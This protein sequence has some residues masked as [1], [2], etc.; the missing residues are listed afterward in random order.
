MDLHARLL[1]LEREL[2]T[3]RRRDRRWWCAAIAAI[4]VALACK[5]GDAKVDDYVRRGEPIVIG[6]VT[7]GTDF[8]TVSDGSGNAQLRSRGLAIT[9]AGASG[10]TTQVLAGRVFGDGTGGAFALG[11]D[12]ASAH[13]SLRSHDTT[14]VALDAGAQVASVVASHQTVRSASLRATDRG[15][16]AN[17]ADGE[18]TAALSATPPPAPAVPASQPPARTDVLDFSELR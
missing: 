7:I 2:A 9:G 3:L 17:V 14:E 11:G 1:R 16:T 6:S 15:G 18:H 12:G 8:V 13:L 4:G 10:A 5:G